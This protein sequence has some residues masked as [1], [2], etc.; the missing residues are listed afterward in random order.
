MSL[1]NNIILLFIV[2]L[3]SSCSATEIPLNKQNNKSDLNTK[4]WQTFKYEND[5][6]E[7]EASLNFKPKSKKLI[8]SSGLLAVNIENDSIEITTTTGRKYIGTI[9]KKESDG[10]FIKINNNQ[11]IFLNNNEIRSITFINNKNLSEDKVTS[12]QTSSSSVPEIKDDFYS[13]SFSEKNNSPQ[14]NNTK[15]MEP[16]SLLSF[17]FGVAGYLPIPIIGGLGWIAAII[18]SKAGRKK[19]DKSPEKYKGRGFAVA[20]KILGWIGVGIAL[21]A[22]ALVIIFL[23]LLF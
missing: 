14:K 10:Y 23:V 1:F 2:G 17:I 11:E 3:L 8:S 12:I 16:M 13:N 20:G 9:T 21:I 19:I 7:F 4:H 6:N 18:L 5:A 15:Q 22:L